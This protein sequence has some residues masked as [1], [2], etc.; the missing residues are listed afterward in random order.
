ME[1]SV[2]PESRVNR[3]PESAPGG[4]GA[5]PFENVSPAADRSLSPPSVAPAEP[6]TGR[7]LAAAANA[8]TTSPVHLP[9]SEAADAPLVAE[10]SARQV[11]TPAF[12]ALAV[13]DAGRPLVVDGRRLREASAVPV[14]S[15]FFGEAEN[16]AGDTVVRAA[17]EK[18]AFGDKDKNFLN[19]GTKEVKTLEAG[20]GITVAKTTA[21]MPEYVISS[22]LASATVDQPLADRTAAIPH[23][24]T[25]VDSRGAVAAVLA[26]ATPFSIADGRTV[27]LQ[28]SV[29]GAELDVRV[30]LHA[31]EVR[32]TFLTDS[33]ELR[34][35]L[36]R[37]WQT[38]TLESSERMLRLSAPVITSNSDPASG[39]GGF[40][41]G[42][43]PQQQD[44][45]ARQ[46]AREFFT[47]A[48]ARSAFPDEAA[49]HVPVLARGFVPP[50]T[51]RHLHTTA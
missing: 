29:D 1:S 22:S 5:L 3:Q 48:A 31:G 6:A 49:E 37:E 25:V 13:A 17:E 50:P 4:R 10:R 8:V 34:S 38:L 7:P 19:S 11:F 36:A 47:P 42:H 32:T 23:A 43:S 44:T 35:A 28:F 40:G 18:S 2:A 21:P 15:S 16:F 24:P 26:A 14:R 33:P 9:G 30:E 51:S 46:Q 12:A 20:V 39:S 27:S 45:G 41:G